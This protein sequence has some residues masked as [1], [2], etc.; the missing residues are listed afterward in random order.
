MPI[1]PNKR[2]Y[3][4]K[5]LAFANCCHPYHL[6]AL[7]PSPEALMRSRFSAFATA[8]VDYI[9][10]TQAPELS[11]NINPENFK[12]E[13]LT[14]KW[15]KLTILET[16]DKSVSFE[17]SMLYNDI[18]YTMK[19]CSEFEQKRGAWIYSKALS[20]ESTEHKMSRNESCPCGSGK[21]Y[22]QC[23]QKG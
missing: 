10:K 9:I 23:C 21:K 2:C 11:Q 18:L 8:N 13:L 4:G 1:S 16:T 22:K 5:E 17:A 20:H 3:C 19:E 12:Q 7:A 6:G 15:V 14:Q